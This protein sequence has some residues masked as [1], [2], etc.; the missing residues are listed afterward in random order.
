MTGSFSSYPYIFRCIHFP[1]RVVI[2]KEAGLAKEKQIKDNLVIGFVDREN[3]YEAQ[4]ELKTV[5]IP[6]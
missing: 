1:P 3:D 2:V 4:K 5:I 6:V